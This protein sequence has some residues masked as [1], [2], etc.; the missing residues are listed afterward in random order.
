MAWQFDRPELGEGL[1]QAFRREDSPFEAARFKLRGL[2]AEST[3]EVTDVDKQGTQKFVGS[4]LLDRGLLV[5]LSEQPQA[6]VITYRRI[7]AR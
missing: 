5:S 1:L 6:A 7:T 4:E 2:D 3:Y